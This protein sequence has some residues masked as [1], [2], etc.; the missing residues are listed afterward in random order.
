MMGSGKGQD[1]R[2]GNLSL[3]VQL[4]GPEAQFRGF[5]GI[6]SRL[7]VCGDRCSSLVRLHCNFNS[8]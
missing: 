8:H 6:E 7:V 1:G 4:K 5:E 2:D 3:Q